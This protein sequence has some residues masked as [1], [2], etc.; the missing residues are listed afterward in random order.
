MSLSEMFYL[1]GWD[2]R[3][4]RGF[5]FDHIRAM[6]LL[7]EVRLEQYIYRKT[8]RGSTRRL[9]PL[10]YI[11]RFLG[12]LFQ[13]FL[14]NS[15][16]PGSVTIGAGL[17]LPHPQNLIIARFADIGE[18]CT[19]YQDVGMVWNS[20]KPAKPSSPKIGT[21]VLIGSSVLIVGDIT[22]GDDVLIGAG[23]LVPKSIPSCSRVT[24]QPAKIVSRPRSAKVAEP[25]SQRHLR[26]P[27]SIWH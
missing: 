12:S 6:L 20:F 11:S 18:F 10:W 8:H 5:S 21:R 13:W 23:A 17:R 4:N 27:Y 22:I 9:M 25:G 16:I 26:D 7:L 19:I 14:C 2:M 1:I 15:N 24:N 3:V